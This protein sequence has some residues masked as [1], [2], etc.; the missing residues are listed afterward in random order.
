MLVILFVQELASYG[1]Y[2]VLI[3]G[4]LQIS[5]TTS[6]RLRTSSR[7]SGLCKQSSFDIS[8]CMS[9]SAQRSVEV[10]TIIREWL[11]GLQFPR[12]VRVGIDVDP[13]SFL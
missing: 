2:F 9:L 10:Q 12:G 6:N 8:D 3:S 7:A 1:N 5:H 4:P 11:G 13:Y